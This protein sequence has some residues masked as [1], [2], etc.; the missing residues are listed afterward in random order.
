MKKLFLLLVTLATFAIAS[1][2]EKTVTG[3]VI[4]AGDGDPLVGASV[5]PIGGGQG[6]S[7]DIDGQF[8]LKVPAHVHTLRVSY[9]G[10]K[11]KTVEI[12][13]G[14]MTIELDNVDNRLDEVMVVAYGTATKEAFTGSAT[15]VGADA[16]EKTQVSNALDALTGKVAG[17]Q[18]N[19]ATGQPGQTT[20]SI[21]VRGI[22]SLNAGNAPLIVVNGT[23]Y[24]GDVNNINPNDIESMTV[25]KDAA[26]NALY[27]ARGANG[28]I[29][30]TTKKGAVGSGA[31]V[32]LDAKWGANS[33]ASQL[34]K[35]VTDPRQY[36]ELYYKYLYNY[37]IGGGMNADEAYVWANQNLTAQ[38]NI[39]LGY[40][41]FTAPAGQ[42]LIGSNG[43]FNPDATPGYKMTYRGQDYLLMPDNWMDAAYKNSLRQEYNLSVSNG[44]DQTQFYLSTSYLNMEGITPNSGYE[45][46]TGRLSADT[47]AKSW[48]KVGADLGYTHYSAKQID[49]DGV[50][51]SS[52]NIF[53]AA[54][55]VAPIYP[56]FIRDGNGNIMK[57]ANGITM[58]DYGDKTNAGLERPVYTQSN[59]ISSALLDTNKYN[60][61]AFMAQG[62][63]EI[64]FLKDFKFTSN[65]AVNVDES[66][67]TSI[68]NPYYG[69]YSDSNGILYKSS[70]R[71]TS[72][73]FQQLLN[74]NHVFNGVHDV[75]V[76]AGHENY[77][78]IYSTL[79]AQRSNMFD[80]NNDELNG[81]VTDGSS[82][83]YT[84]KYNNEGWLFR[85][86]YSYD[87]KYFGSVSFRRDASSRF[88]PGNRWGSFWSAGAAW[89]I[90]KESWF[91]ADWVNMLKIKASYGEQG[92]DNIGNFLYVNTYNIVNGSGSPAATPAT[93]GNPNISWEKNGNLNYG[94]EF[95]LFESRLSGSVEG[96]YRKTS[97]MLSW[98]PLP[99]SFGWTGYYDNIGD[100]TNTGVEIDLNGIAVRTRNLTWTINANLTFYKNKLAYLPEERKTMTVDGVNGYSSGNYYYGEGVPLY[101]FRLPTYAGTDPETGEALYLH[102]VTQG[103]LDDGF[104]AGHQVGDEVA[105]PWTIT[106]GSKSVTI[107]TS[108]YHL[109]GSALP[110][111]YGGFGTSLN[112]FG[113]DFSIDFTYSLGGQS[114]DGTYASYMSG[115]SATSRGQAFHADL[116]DAWTAENSASNIP[117]LLYDDTYATSSSSRWLISANYLNLQNINFGY[118]LP[119]NIVKKMFLTKLRVYMQAENVW[120]WSKRQG[121]DPRQSVSGGGGNTYY[122]PIRTVSGGLSITF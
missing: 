11:T 108:D 93:M 45:R 67:S 77:W 18:I 28:V 84:T 120:Y 113:F 12:T 105:A 89:I 86:Q 31:T 20:P 78:N 92:N 7:T 104:F 73:T 19:N 41:T 8:T 66:R 95:D 79:S 112:A 32:S 30:I 15:V 10:M 100:M 34:Y 119:Q 52:G 72:Y 55:Q 17:V 80:P 6:V 29:L 49:E 94:V 122:S 75:S 50:S 64:R 47:Q 98:F 22:S 2:Q 65:N 51:N 62:Y 58:Y 81:A 44:T 87:N 36:Y 13:A 48:L 39:G 63:A 21:L 40:Q 91:K 5:M 71:S 107:S 74:W 38:N 88:A 70:S 3:Q 42:Y 114:Y 109:H 33:R 27:G 4:Y 57:D 46:F 97:D 24:P 76:L 23:P 110:K 25:L 111:V 1:A 26:S 60:G 117:R 83:S 54:T 59:A 9:V 14:K 118:S 102:T 96:F 121:L 43:R 61:N 85:G 69:S 68:T 101:T 16:I 90:S 37:G 82:G 56:L 35:T 116:F 103:N 106:N 99:P 115:P 53:A